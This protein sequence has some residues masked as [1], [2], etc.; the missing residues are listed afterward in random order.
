MGQLP[1]YIVVLFVI[2]LIFLL[3]NADIAKR[4]DIKEL[5]KNIN[6][7]KLILADIIKSKF[8]VQPCS[9]C[10]ENIM[11]LI[12]ISPNGRSVHYQC[13]HCGKKMHDTAG[14]ADAQKAI[15]IWNELTDLVNKY[16]NLKHTTSKIIIGFETSLAPLPYEQTSRRT[17]PESI[18]NEVWRRDGGCCKKCGS[19]ENLQFDHIVPI[20]KNG[21]TSVENIELLCQMCNLK[22]GAKI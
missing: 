1:E 13:N 22:K 20:S 15:N 18:R 12:E 19:R 17:I 21:A 5:S 2:S 7:K 3:F 16:D 4:R 6:D 9:R 10:N 11:T 8:L 14:C